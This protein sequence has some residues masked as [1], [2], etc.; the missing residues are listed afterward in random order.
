MLGVQHMDVSKINALNFLDLTYQRRPLLPYLCVMAGRSEEVRDWSETL[1][2]DLMKALSAEWNRVKDSDDVAVLTVGDKRA[3]MIGTFARSAKA[4][5]SAVAEP[6]RAAPEADEDE[7][8]MHD[9][10]PTD[11]A[12]VQAAL[13]SKIAGIT[14]MLERKRRGEGPGD[15][16][17]GVDDARGAAL[18]PQRQSG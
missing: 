3:R 14:Q 16:D 8:D 5:Q 6:K 11:P 17:L 1:Q 15:G 2:S 4:I 7:A 10:H 9:D 12:D 18:A 13:E